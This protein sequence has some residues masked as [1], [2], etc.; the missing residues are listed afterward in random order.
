MTMTVAVILAEVSDDVA[1]LPACMLALAVAR[2][3]GD[4]LSPSFDHGMIETLRVPFLRECPPSVFEVL[5]AKDVMAP[6]PVRLLEVTT[7]RDIVQVLR[8]SAHNGFPV[9]S[10]SC[11]S[12][13]EE[14][15]GT[16]LVGLILRRQLL[17]LLKDKVWESQAYG[18]PL[19]VS[20]KDKFLTSFFV[21]AHVDY[22]AYVQQA[23]RYAVEGIRV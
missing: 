13:K 1:T 5:T 2:F 20:K 16:F 22:D 18:I 21:M 23:R 4:S 9:V 8:D 12:S 10:G 6:R 17:V 11:L 3:V 19:T 15:R 14:G 7:V